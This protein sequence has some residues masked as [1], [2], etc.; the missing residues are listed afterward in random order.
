MDWLIYAVAAI[1]AFVL[2]AFPAIFKRRSKAFNAKKILAEMSD[3]ERAD[4]TRLFAWQGEDTLPDVET[5]ANRIR[6][7]MFESALEGTL[8]TVPEQRVGFAPKGSPWL[9][10]NVVLNNG[11]P[12]DEISGLLQ[13][14]VDLFVMQLDREA[15]ESILQSDEFK[16]P[17][18]QRAKAQE[19]L[20]LLRP[21]VTRSI[22]VSK[23]LSVEFP[24]KW[25]NPESF[26]MFCARNGQIIWELDPASAAARL[27]R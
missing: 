7:S 23:T 1:L 21:L 26:I 22:S 2:F 25:D 9:F 8:S 5:A 17:T 11:V 19:L 3:Q 10:Y 4:L 13:E 15:I 20:E 18:T 14:M 27:Q 24:N 16:D 6:A 12:I